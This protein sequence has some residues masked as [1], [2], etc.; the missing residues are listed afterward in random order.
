MSN[1]TFIK[2]AVPRKDTGAWIMQTWLAFLTAVSISSFGIAATPGDV[3]VKGFLFIGLAFVL[4]ATFTLSKTLRDNQAK[5]VD[6]SQWIM[7][8]WIAFMLASGLSLFGVMNVPGEAIHKGFGLMSL[9]FSVTASFTLAKTLRDNHEAAQ[10]AATDVN[11][12][13]VVTRDEA[14]NTPIA[15]SFSQLDRDGDG[16]VSKVEVVR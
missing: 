11:R 13:G 8:V 12:D 5:R 15:A 14:F 16:V 2:T 6:T 3:W 10:F 7:Q 1:I 4:S 9:A